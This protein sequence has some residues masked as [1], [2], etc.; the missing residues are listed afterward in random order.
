MRL[1]V[2]ALPGLL[3]D[4]AI[5]D[6]KGVIKVL[7]AGGQ[8]QVVVGNKV[9]ALFDCIQDAYHFGEEGACAD[10][11]EKILHGCKVRWEIS[12]MARE[13]ERT[14]SKTL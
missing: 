12:S 7:E 14:R 11:A 8:Y 6:A 1:I 2:G 9:E 13:N 10:K 3:K 4:H 5:T